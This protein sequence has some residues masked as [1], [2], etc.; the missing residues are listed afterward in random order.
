MIK[1]D[2][3]GEKMNNKG[4]A[5][6]TLIYG[7]S[8]MGIML[9][10]I[11]MSTMSNNRTNTREMA[12]S[13]ENELISFSKA[14]S[15]FEPIP[16]NNGQQSQHYI[17]G[18]GQS[19]WYRIELW[20]A[21][22]GNNSY[23]AY[24]SGMIQL[25]EGD[26]L[27]FNIGKKDES[28]AGQSSDVRLVDGSYNDPNSYNTR[29]MVA[30]GGG[31]GKNAPGGTVYGYSASSIAP[32]G[33][34]LND[35]TFN[36]SSVLLGFN[37][38]SNYEVVMIDGPVGQ[39]GGGS[40]Y[41]SSDKN[42]V[43]GISMIA[44]YAGS[45][46]GIKQTVTDESGESKIKTY[47]FLDGMML[48]GVNKGDGKAKITKIIDYNENLTD[49]ENKLPIVNKKMEN[50]QYIKDC[51]SIDDGGKN[52]GRLIADDESQAMFAM[53]DG[54]AILKQTKTGEKISSQKKYCWDYELQEP[55]TLDE[56]TVMQNNKKVDYE[57]HT[58][59]VSKNGTTWDYLKKNGTGT[60]LSETETA[61]G[62]HIS[63]YQYDST[64]DLPKNGN[65][66]IIPVLDENKVVQA[67][68]KE[69][70]VSDQFL[71]AS[72]LTGEKNQKWS[73]ELID[74]RIQINPGV[75]CNEF[76]IVELKRHKAMTIKDDENKVGNKLV[77]NRSFNNIKRDETQ[78]WKIEAVG[79]GTY[80]IKSVA[81]PFNKSIASGNIMPLTGKLQDIYTMQISK[82]D[83]NGQRFKLISLE[84]LK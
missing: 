63:A 57:D 4:F 12:E 59:E 64:E 82:N 79:N 44:G 17:V 52:N 55:T 35:G 31:A 7:L 49:E 84:Y 60:K 10:A 71:T 74:E 23:G 27:Y 73:I 46:E 25:E 14:E 43:G 68:S 19:G 81:P 39:N 24:T 11:L 22:G 6:S 40:G 66:Y 16:Q 38:T 53:K 3:V 9:I 26:L 62:T 28:G 83:I 20:G 42:T 48:P 50:V 2:K 37:D 15:S 65:Y 69:D 21:Q 45:A 72:L 54:T 8:I 18:D 56:I 36:I 75:K 80:T 47:Y 13:I 5:I 78:I 32:S 51:I 29:I 70:D 41:K 61:I 67:P 76:K 58:I 77:A 1:L 34:V 33:I 30:A